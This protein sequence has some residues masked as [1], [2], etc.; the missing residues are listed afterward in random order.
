M[1][2]LHYTFFVQWS[3]RYRGSC[4][5]T[6]QWRRPVQ[7]LSMLRGEKTVELTKPL[8][9]QVPRYEV[10][11]IWYSS[12]TVTGF[13]SMPVWYGKLILNSAQSWPQAGGPHHWNRLQGF[14]AFKVIWDVLVKQQVS[15]SLP[16][17]DTA[18]LLQECFLAE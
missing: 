5:W 15:S 13:S 14:S 9:N 11:N 8:N 4:L 12:R 2:L 7:V 18:V 17:M 10:T 1:I 16:C 6:W 3:I